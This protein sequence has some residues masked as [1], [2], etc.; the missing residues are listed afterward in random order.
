MAYRN[1]DIQLFPSSPS[2][3][4][5]AV[6]LEEDRSMGITVTAGTYRLVATNSK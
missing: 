3:T 4:E 2:E 5:T 6:D 1:W